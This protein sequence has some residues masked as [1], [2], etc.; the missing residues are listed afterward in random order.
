MRPHLVSFAERDVLLAL[1]PPETMGSIVANT[2][3]VAE[4]RLARDTP[5]VF[6]EMTPDE[7]IAWTEDMAERVVAPPDDAPAVCLLDS[8]TT[9]KL[10]HSYEAIAVEFSSGLR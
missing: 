8:G 7:Q 3:A 6:M 4:Q 9:R 10:A 1:A 2:D 5:A